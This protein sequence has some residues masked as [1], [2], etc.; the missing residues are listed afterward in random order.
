MVSCDP[1]WN[2]DFPAR[3]EI[4]RGGLEEE[5]RF[6]RYSV[7]QLLYMIGIVP[8]NSDDLLTS[9]G[10]FREAGLAHLFAMLHKGSY[11]CH[12]S[13]SKL[14]IRDLTGGYVEV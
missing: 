2:L 8:A 4:A 10:M 13:H 14:F 9:E 12:D 5:E 7:V 3:L 11:R 6:L 1:C